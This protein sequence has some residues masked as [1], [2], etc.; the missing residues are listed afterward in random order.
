MRNLH[1]LDKYRLDFSHLFGSTGDDKMGV[2]GIPSP[3]EDCMLR[4]MA[5][6][7]EGWDHLSVSLP[8]RC[9][10]WE[11]MEFLRRAFWLPE[12]TVFQL[13]PPLDQYINNH[14]YCLHLWRSWD[15]PVPMPPAEFVGVK[16]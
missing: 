16:V 1:E 12:D 13:H 2:F 4:C 6:C 9:P 14:P 5:A 8:D 11:E 7:G 3:F 10:T 15:Q